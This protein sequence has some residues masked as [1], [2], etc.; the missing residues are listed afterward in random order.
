M[1]DKEKRKVS[2][3]EIMD[4]TDVIERIRKATGWGPR[5][6]VALLGVFF[7]GLCIGLIIM[8]QRDTLL[9]LAQ[10]QGAP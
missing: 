6:Y 5:E 9:L 3:E 10:L 7:M 4:I 1:T 8:L 2:V